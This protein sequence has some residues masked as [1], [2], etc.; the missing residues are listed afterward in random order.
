MNLFPPQLD[1]V[2][3]ALLEDINA[4][5]KLDGPLMVEKVEQLLQISSPPLNRVIG[6]F[7]GPFKHYLQFSR[8]TFTRLKAKTSC[9]VSL[10]LS[11]DSKC[12]EM[13]SKFDGIYPNVFTE[14][15]Q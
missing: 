11:T 14:W 13:L 7:E 15:T 9:S 2:Q 5:Y 6:W 12:Y 8:S 4:L 1:P 3:L 10:L